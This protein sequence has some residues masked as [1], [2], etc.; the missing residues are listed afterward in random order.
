L[1][2][3]ATEESEERIMKR[4]AYT[5][6]GLAGIAA[7][8]W[9][10]AQP[11]IGQDS[12]GNPP[13]EDK[14]TAQHDPVAG[15]FAI[16]YGTVLNEKQQAE[17]DRL[18]EDKEQALR[19][20]HDALAEATTW[21][22]KS[23]ARAKI[24]DLEHQVRA[25]MRKILKMSPA[26]SG[27]S[28][29]HSSPDQPQ[30]VP[31]EAFGSYGQAIYG[32]YYA[33]GGAAYGYGYYPGYSP[34]YGYYGSAYPG[35]GDWYGNYYGPWNR[36]HRYGDWSARYPVGT[37]SSPAPGTGTRGGSG[38]TTQPPQK[39]A[40]PARPAPSRPAPSHR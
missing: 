19:A 13:K 30:P 27:Q 5:R 21:K 29:P 9:L 35:Y 18:K 8:A 36:K 3:Q 25:A 14:K 39:P 16:P 26:N 40:A 4:F 17:Y 20:A 11:C 22:D 37:G 2:N 1:K 12:E 33:P 31:Q 24:S 38:N 10:C 7:A 23:D 6:F 32:N 28:Q 34:G 15:L